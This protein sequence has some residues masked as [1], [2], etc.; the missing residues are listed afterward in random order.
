VGVT[1]ANLPFALHLLHSAAALF[2][3]MVEAQASVQVANNIAARGSMRAPAPT[4]RI[5]LHALS[6]AV[7]ATSLL[8]LCPPGGLP[9]A[10]IA[11]SYT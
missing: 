1:P 2:P 6:A 8:S 7:P 5:A 3:H 4:P 9:L 10:I 11:G